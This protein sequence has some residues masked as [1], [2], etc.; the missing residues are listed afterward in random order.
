M[1][2]L[3][4]KWSNKGDITT[5]KE[6]AVV[7]DV[8]RATT[9]ITTAL[10]KGA[11]SIIPTEDIDD[12]FKL[13]KKHHALL[14]GERKYIKVKGFDLGNSPLEITEDIVKHK[15]IIFTST[16]FPTAFNAS[17]ESPEILIG[18]ILNVTAVTKK[19]YTLASKKGYNICF[20]LA[21]YPENKED[22]AFAGASGKILKNCDIDEDVKNA[23]NYI[24][25]K[26]LEQCI[27]N[28]SHAKKLINLGFKDDVEFACK[29][30]I[31]N[32]VP[33]AKH[34]KIIVSR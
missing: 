20:M 10:Y 12:A 30:D 8:L 17:K 26:T 9:T 5:E 33:F 27:K 28:A 25:E 32:I 21:G 19:A 16:N 34:K 23:I 4:I 2:R 31:F 1:I 22:L 14:M 24:N 29:K 15:K 11:E 18:S 6:I 13:A 7:A 3:N